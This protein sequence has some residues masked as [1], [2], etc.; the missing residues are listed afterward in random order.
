MTQLRKPA[1]VPAPP[2][3]NGS[4][5]PP[6]PP[7]TLEQLGLPPFM[8]SNLVLRWIREHGSGSLT[9]LRKG[10]KLSYP[11]VESTFQQLRQQQLIDIKSTVGSDFLFTL[12]ATGRQFAMERSESCSYA[13]PAPVPIGQY[14]QVV[15]AQ[16]IPIQPFPEQVRGMFHDLVLP[17]EI[18]D[19]IGTAL[20]S[21]RPVFIY[22][23]SGNGK[24]SIIERLPRVY[25]D[26]I[27]VP[28]AVEVD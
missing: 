7:L 22:G 2:Q 3:V 18:L 23:P 27:F 14:A 16:R 21:Q 12:T 17:D 6:P 20:V 4:L 24:T 1:P 28:Y 13:G 25:D 9:M 10:L 8:V 11:V 26:F 19:R 5:A 15:R